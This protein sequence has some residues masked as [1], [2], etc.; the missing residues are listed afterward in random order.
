MAGTLSSIAG[1][2]NINLKNKK[3]GIVVAEWNDEIT[4]RKSVV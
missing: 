1:K 2:S 3:F 4:D